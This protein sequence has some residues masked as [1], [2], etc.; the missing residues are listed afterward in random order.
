MNAKHLKLALLSILVAGAGSAHAAV[1]SAATSSQNLLDIRY[2]STAKGVTTQLELPLAG[3]ANYQ[4]GN[5]IFEMRDSQSGAF[6]GSFIGYC[7][8]LSQWASSSFHTYEAK[9]FDVSFARY[10][11]VTKL[12]GHAY[13]GSLN[14]STKAAGFQLALWE[15][16]SDDGNLAS[17]VVR[18][19]S[20][21]SGLVKSEAQSLLNALSSWSDS[22]TA[23][24]LTFYENAMYQNYLAVTGTGTGSVPAIPE[25]DNYALLLAGLGLMGFVARRRLRD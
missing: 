6:A 13:Q 17:G 1:S 15:V 12:F 20:N 23:Y 21:T 22:G 18:T 14:D 7:V 25:A 9:S 11:D 8:D 3:I 4:L 2:D 19:T 5:Y 16:F 24:Q 10:N